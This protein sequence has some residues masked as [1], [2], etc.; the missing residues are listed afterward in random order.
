VISDDQGGGN[1]DGYGATGFVPST[2]LADTSASAGFYCRTDYTANNVYGI[3]AL[4][5]AATS[6]IGLQ[7]K[8]DNSGGIARG[9]IGDVALDVQNAST[10]SQGLY[11]VSRTA[12]NVLK[13]YKNASQIGTTETGTDSV[14]LPNV[15]ITILG[16][17]NNG[18]NTGNSFATS[19]AFFFIGDGLTDTDVSNLYTH[20]QAYQTDLSRNV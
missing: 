14:G 4:N 3:G 7:A 12:N 20:V 8:S 10:N 17:N 19:Y 16:Y 6:F 2:E 15:A 13:I 18:S 11:V 1:G 9:F 5:A